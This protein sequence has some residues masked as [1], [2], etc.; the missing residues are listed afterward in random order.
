[1]ELSV[2]SSPF[3]CVRVCF[4]SPDLSDH[5]GS[6]PRSSI[7]YTYIPLLNPQSGGWNDCSPDIPFVGAPDVVPSACLVLTFFASPVS[8]C[9]LS[10]GHAYSGTGE[11]FLV[12]DLTSPSDRL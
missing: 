9:A 8:C 7:S 11:L 1:M 6:T 5:E 2:S 3:P 10:V 12:A 4:G